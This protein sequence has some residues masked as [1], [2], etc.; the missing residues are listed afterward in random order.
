MATLT[1]AAAARLQKKGRYGA[2]LGLFLVVKPSGSKSW[3]LRVKVGGKRLDRG[4]G[5]FPAVGLPEARRKAEAMRTE[6]RTGPVPAPNTR[7]QE[8]T[9]PTFREASGRVLAQRKGQWS[10]KWALVWQREFEKHVYPRLGDVPVDQ[11][12]RRDCLELLTP[13]WTRIPTTAG[14]LRQRMRIVFKWAI[15]WEYRPDNPAGEA[16]DGALPARRVAVKH[17]DALPHAQVEEAIAAV[18]AGPGRPLT[19]LSIA[20][21]VL[22]AARSG[23]VRGMRW[24]EVS[25]DGRTWEIPGDRMKTGQPH[26]VPLSLQAQRILS[27]AHREFSDVPTG[28]VPSPDAFVFMPYKESTQQMG[29]T[30]MLVVVKAAGVP[31]KVHGFRS[32]FRDWAE[33]ESGASHAAIE[34]SLSHRVG[35]AVERAYFR[36][37]LMEQRRKLMQAWADY[38]APL[39]PGDDGDPVVVRSTWAWSFH[40]RIDV[41]RNIPFRLGW[42]DPDK[43]RRVNSLREQLRALEASA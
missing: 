17:H 38:V 10:A 41:A 6:L 9:A 40:Q 42:I 22:T 15:S 37:D 1:A 30:T 27:L 8:S 34:L 7:K 36:S 4:L 14:R 23:E 28:N 24:S 19:K 32:S 16:L 11:I 26:K 29:H 20:F 13:L 33:E 12:S 35:S 43:Q 25:E 21:T 18:S 3:V 2:G 39:G 31:C 5:S